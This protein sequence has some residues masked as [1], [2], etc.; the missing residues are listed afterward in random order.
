MTFAEYRMSGI[1]QRTE[2]AWSNARVFYVMEVGRC[3][4]LMALVLAVVDVTPFPYRIE[5]VW[6]RMWFIGSWSVMMGGWSLVLARR[7]KPAG[8]SAHST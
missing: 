1:R 7:S 6:E 5:G 8:D 3:A 2:L 4:A